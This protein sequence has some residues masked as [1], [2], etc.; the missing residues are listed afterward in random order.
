MSM[1]VD[2]G[3][4]LLGTLTDAAGQAHPAYHDGT[5]WHPLGEVQ[6]GYTEVAAD[7]VVPSAGSVPVLSFAV[8]YLGIG[9]FARLLLDVPEVDFT[10][11]SGGELEVS[12]SDGTTTSV[13]AH[14][15]TDRSLGWPLRSARRLPI[16]GAGTVTYTVTAQSLSG[17]VT[18]HADADVA[19]GSMS[20]SLT[21]VA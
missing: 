7:V 10:A 14:L 8:T 2:Q 15:H 3:F 4:P 18:L 20:A 11:T 13:L 21:V 6:L 17:A 12:V 1:N 19:Y 5:R 9:T 16:A